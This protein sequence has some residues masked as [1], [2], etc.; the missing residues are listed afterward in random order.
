M[1]KRSIV[2]ILKD[3]GASLSTSDQP[4]SDAKFAPRT[5]S[6]VQCFCSKCNGTL[7]DPRTKKTH[8]MKAD[9]TPLHS[10]QS[11]HSPSI[12]PNETP[13]SQ[14]LVEPFDSTMEIDDHLA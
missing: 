12:L 4:L 3:D 2:N 9:L 6:K 11:T 7:V 1:R 14:L 5:W 10:E 8:E 13:M